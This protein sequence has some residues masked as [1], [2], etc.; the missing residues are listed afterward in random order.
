MNF[1]YNN[2][3]KKILLYTLKISEALEHR[4]LTANATNTP[5]MD[6]VKTPTEKMPEPSKVERAF[7]WWLGHNKSGTF[8]L[9]RLGLLLELGEV[10]KA[11]SVPVFGYFSVTFFTVFDLTGYSTVIR[12]VRRVPPHRPCAFGGPP[13]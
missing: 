12:D 7:C 1:L 6:S 11:K 2:N 4:I 3:F 13:L 10:A 5:G 9:E 8:A